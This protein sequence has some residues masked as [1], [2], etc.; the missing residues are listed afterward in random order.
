[1]TKKVIHIKIWEC[2]YIGCVKQFANN[3]RFREHIDEHF[4]GTRWENENND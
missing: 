4:I 3:Q 1:M 2:P